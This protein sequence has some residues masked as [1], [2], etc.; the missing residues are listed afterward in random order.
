MKPPVT[1]LTKESA[2]R[3]IWYSSEGEIHSSSGVETVGKCE[4]SSPFLASVWVDYARKNFAGEW[5]SL[6]GDAGLDWLYTPKTHEDLNAFIDSAKAERWSHLAIRPSEHAALLESGQRLFAGLNFRDLRRCQLDI[7][8]RGTRGFPDPTVAGDRLLAVGLKQG[9]RI[10]LIELE[11]DSD[12]GEKQL[13]MTLQETLLRLDPDVIEGHN[14]F[15]F[16]FNYLK[17]R[18]RRL[19][20]PCQW[21]RF[22]QRATFRRSRMRIAERWIDYLRCDIP[23]RAIF[24]TWIM[25]QVWDLGARS[26]TSYGLK[27]VSRELGITQPENDRTYLPGDQI[28]STFEHDRE[29][30]REYLRDDL[31]ETEGL[32]DF[33][34]PTY[35]SQVGILPMTL[36]E[37]TLRGTAAKVDLLLLE[38]YRKAGHSLPDQRPITFPFEGGF[39]KSFR[40]GVFQKILHFDVA[41]LYPSILLWIGRAPANDPLGAFL[42]ML[43][44]LRELRLR[45]KKRSQEAKDPDERR[46][47]NARQTSYKILINSF[48]GY[49]GFSEARFGDGEL[50]AEVTAKGRELLQALIQKFES[51]GQPVL[52]A[53]TD[54]LYVHAPEFFD[55]P[56]TLLDAVSSLLPPG[57]ELEIGGRYDSMLCYKAKNYALY[58]DGKMITR[59]SALRSRGMEPFLRE[60]TDFLLRS[61]LGIE[62]GSIAQRLRDVRNQIQQGTMPGGKLAKAEYLSMAP[63]NYQNQVD[64]GKKNRRA[65]LEAAMQMSPLPAMGDLVRYYISAGTSGKQPDWQKAVPLEKMDPETTP[66]DP[67]YYMK[68][69][70]EWEK[71]YT[72]FLPEDNSQEELR[73]F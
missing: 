37:A 26:L 35:T 5:T 48:Y 16:D 40:T 66:Y 47:Y 23:G 53:D 58:G 4:T 19:R 10:H 38:R 8:T 45:Y 56:E 27:D 13:L 70:A 3:G 31:R 2:L 15:R 22:G 36:Q 69:L 65:S 71:R 32:A 51:L 49:L 54:G 24:D 17:E 52:E 6:T 43:E 28:A 46:E 7:E 42:P 9:E 34:L 64:T 11:E 1:P 29:T 73:L 63:E 33:L 72:E 39:S 68:R 61:L 60:L 14:I 59:G 25:I 67:Q 20:V 62:A 50:A 18:S 55:Q 41:S 44:E 57:I 30:F 21:G 12:E